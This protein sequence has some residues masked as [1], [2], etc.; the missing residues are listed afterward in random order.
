MLVSC[1]AMSCL[2]YKKNLK[3]ISALFLIFKK[4]KNVALAINV[5]ITKTKLKIKAK[6]NDKNRG[7]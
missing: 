6:L 1:L 2:N 4:V 3:W 5:T 7:K